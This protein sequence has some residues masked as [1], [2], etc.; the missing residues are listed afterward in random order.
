MT[1]GANRLLYWAPRLITIAFA[2]FLS[3]FALDV[4]SEK[5]PLGELLLALLIHL[6][7]AA[8][9]LLVLAFAWRWEW[10]GAVLFAGL[11][12]FYWLR[13][14]RHPN[15]IVV[16]SGP[17]FVVAGLF[18]VNWVKRNQ[19]HSQSSRTVSNRKDPRRPAPAGPS[20]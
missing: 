16:I 5:H 1:I 11:G 4:F 17:L 2:I 13:N 8:I 15:W 6:V 10:A 14:L 9:I 3:A 7:P 12:I 18:L 20:G 19:L